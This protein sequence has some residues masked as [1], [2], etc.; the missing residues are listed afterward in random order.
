MHARAFATIV[1]AVGSIAV[2]RGRPAATAAIMSRDREPGKS[3]PLHD[4]HHV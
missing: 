1:L 3:K 4:G 2:L